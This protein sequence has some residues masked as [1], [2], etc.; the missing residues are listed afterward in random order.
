M[1]M[2]KKR[3]AWFRPGPADECLMQLE[4]GNAT[5]YDCVRD[6]IKDKEGYIEAMAVW[7]ATWP[8]EQF[9]IIQFENLT[10]DAS[11]TAVL[12]DVMRFVDIDPSK[13]PQELPQ[14]NSRKGDVNPE[15]WKM[16][17]RLKFLDDSMRVGDSLATRP[18]DP[19]LPHSKP[20]ATMELAMPK[21]FRLLTDRRTARSTFSLEL[22]TLRCP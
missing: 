5:M 19:N 3:P 18:T 11:H 21:M 4:Q 6:L 9:M 17:K 22:S 13:G 7:L 2:L 14:A 8:T 20:I 1:E 10:A 16:K 15:G 12:N